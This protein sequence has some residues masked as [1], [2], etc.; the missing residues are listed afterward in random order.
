MV[1]FNNISSDTAKDS[2]CEKLEQCQF[3]HWTKYKMNDNWYIPLT[4]RVWGPYHKLRTEFFS[5]LI[6]GSRAKHAGHKSKGKK[7]GSVTYGTDRE[8]EVSKI[9]IISLLCVWRAQERF[10]FKRNAFKFLMHLKI[11][12]SQ[13]EIVFKLLACFHTQFRVKKVLNVYLL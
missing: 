9:F 2:Q 3:W 4:N 11:K 13:F 12:R 8:N 10:L 5:P 1:N 7:W 6:Y